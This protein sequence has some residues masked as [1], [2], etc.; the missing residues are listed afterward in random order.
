M[1]LHDFEVISG[2]TEILKQQSVVLRSPSIIPSFTE[3]DGTLG[4]HSK[5]R[6]PLALAA[7]RTNA[8]AP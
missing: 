2:S 1:Q 3:C 6:T 5:E 7:A 8:I 4:S